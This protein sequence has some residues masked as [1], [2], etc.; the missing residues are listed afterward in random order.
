M[1]FSPSQIVGLIEIET[2]DSAGSNRLL[3]LGSE[4]E[5]LAGL[6][7]WLTSPAVVAADEQAGPRCRAPSRLTGC[8]QCL[9]PLPAV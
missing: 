4:E 8:R 7:T 2:L 6:L 1:L 9:S 5:S 3:P